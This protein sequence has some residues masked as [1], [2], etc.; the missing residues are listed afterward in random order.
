MRDITNL[1]EL[2]R[3][4]SEFVMMIILMLI[5]GGTCSTAGGIKQYRVYMIYKSILWQVKNALLPNRSVS[6]RYIWEGDLKG[7]VNDG[8]I[9]SIGSFV[10]AYLGIYI[11]GALVI[12]LSVNPATGAAYSLREAL[13]EFASALGTVGLSVGVSS[14]TAPLHVLWIEI[15]GMLL[16]RLEIFVMIIA[17]VK[18]LRD[19]RSCLTGP[20]SL[21]IGQ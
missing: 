4:K 18:M 5:G 1:K 14:V 8:Q 19:I 13:F 21:G 17:L 10:F 7:Y 6:R 16:G 3:L 15:L 20:R 11:A 9:R 2:D 12:A